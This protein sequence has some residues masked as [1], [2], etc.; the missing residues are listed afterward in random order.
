MAFGAELTP[1]IER[2]S[3]EVTIINGEGVPAGSL[4]VIET[5]TPNF[6]LTMHLRDLETV[7]PYELTAVLYYSWPDREKIEGRSSDH[8][9]RNQPTWRAIIQV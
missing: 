1:F 9:L 2:P 6:N 3:L 7:N 5:L 8:F 4:N